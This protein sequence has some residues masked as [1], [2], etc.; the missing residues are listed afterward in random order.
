M[1]GTHT[2]ARSTNTPQPGGT[3]V[4]IGAMFK[5]A[6]LN[7]PSD[8]QARHTAGKRSYTVSTRKRGR[9]IYARPANGRYDDIAIDATARQAAPFQRERQDDG[10]AISIRDEDI[11]RKVR[12]RKTAN[13][14]LFAV[15]ASW[16]MAAA[17]R[18]EAT[19]GAIMSLLVDAYQK[20]DRVAMVSFQRDRA[21]LVLPPTSSVEMAKSA[22]RD[23]P[24]G[25]KTP[26]SAG[27]VLAF[28]VIQREL[29]QDNE[30]VP[31]MIILTDGAGNVSM[32]GMPPREEGLMVAR[33][34]AEK[35]IRCIVIN[36]EH[37]SLDRGLAQ[38]LATML[39]GPCYTL[40]DLRADNLYAMVR[41][42]L[43]S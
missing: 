25:G 10:M 35:Q 7:S 20:R 5:P 38:E 32:T 36:T 43:T 24:V 19:K 2:D 6:R 42:E 40:R 15:D 3:Q 16:S 39:D 27:L 34:F 23:I 22:L 41:K 30:I 21:T 29:L 1:R 11:Q 28:E 4:S 12:V 18:M 9:Y 13:L 37:E 26:L 31:M 8:R 14:V 17:E 33:M